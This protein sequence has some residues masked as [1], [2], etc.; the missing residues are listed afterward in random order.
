M[1]SGEVLPAES[2]GG[3]EEPQIQVEIQGSSSSDS[4]SD[5][6]SGLADGICVGFAPGAGTWFWAAM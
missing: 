1:I 3:V 4:G 5:T 6:E 2:R